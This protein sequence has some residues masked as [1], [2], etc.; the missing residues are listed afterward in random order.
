MKIVRKIIKWALISLIG[1]MVVITVALEINK[2]RILSLIES[3]I[4][5]GIEG[6][7]SYNNGSVSFLTSFPDL[8]VRFND[9]LLT[10]HSDEPEIFTSE[11]LYFSLDLSFLLS[12]KREPIVSQISIEDPIINLIKLDDDLYNFDLLTDDNSSTSSLNYRIEFFEI[13]NYAVKYTDRQNNDQSYAIMGPRISGSASFKDNLITLGLKNELLT[14]AAQQGIFEMNPLR[15]ISDLHISSDADWSSIQILESDLKINDLG[16]QLNGRIQQDLE[17]FSYELDI[18]SVDGEIRELMSL[19][20]TYYV[21][22]YDQLTSEGKFTVAGHIEGNSKD[23]FPLYELDIQVENGSLKYADSEVSIDQMV[24]NAKIANL[25]S[26]DMISVIHID[27][28]LIR[29][30]NNE[31]IGDLSI[32]SHDDGWLIS[33]NMATQLDLKQIGGVLPLDDHS[34]LEGKINGTWEAQDLLIDNANRPV[35][36]DSQIDLLIQE[37]NWENVSKERVSISEGS[38]TGSFQ[39]LTVKA[40]DLRWDELFAGDVVMEDMSLKDVIESDLSGRLKVDAE[41]IDLRDTQGDDTSVSW[42]DLHSTDLHIDV[43]AKRLRYQDYRIEDLSLKGNIRPTSSSFTVEGAK[44]NDQN[45]KADAQLDNIWPY[46]TRNDVLSGRVVLHAESLVM[47]SFLVAEENN[48]EPDTS[49]SLPSN[50]D[51]EFDYRISEASYKGI[52]LNNTTGQAQLSHGQLVFKNK[53]AISEGS[54]ELVGKWDTRQDQSNFSLNSSVSEVPISSL[55]ALIPANL[56][57]HAL[58]PFIEGNFGLEFEWQSDLSPV[59]QPI[60]STINSDGFLQTKNGKINGI[61]PLEKL[62][63]YVRDDVNRA[64][65]LQDINTFFAVKDGK[66]FLRE[67]NVSKGDIGLV[68]SG[69]Y[70]FEKDVDMTLVM[71]LNPKLLRQDNLLKDFPGMAESL[72][73]VEKIRALGVAELKFRLEGIVTDPS[74]SLQGVGFKPGVANG[75]QAIKEGLEERIDQVLNNAID[76]NLLDLSIPGILTAND[77]VGNINKAPLNSNSLD[78]IFTALGDSMNTPNRL[79][80]KVNMDSVFSNQK[81]K[82]KNIK[83]GLLSIRRKN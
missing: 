15:I 9:V 68:I 41:R 40:D 59:L 50:M 1:L 5:K 34:T 70:D 56:G 63:Q 12:R 22:K 45:V 21:N 79:I 83:Q 25:N 52:L 38:I 33:S 10:G 43:T 76:S 49:T 77:S 16:L 7:F 61:K 23:Q 74:V 82:L 54:F 42:G 27:T 14:L 26:S 73:A 65:N 24:T 2:S 29:S 64:W 6:T 11:S 44:V 39:S 71:Q 31:I 80:E 13:K 19:L 37:V 81:E 48:T 17:D 55:L 47:D 30:D 67:F 69:A 51:I 4:N 18:A 66:I 46:I 78:S 36:N 57:L 72:Q 20:S 32:S 75:S 28:L 58:A 62:L 35:A 53:S 60:V 8:G 3:S